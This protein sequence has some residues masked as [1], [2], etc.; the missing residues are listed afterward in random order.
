MA[1]PAPPSIEG[2]GHSFR[3][4]VPLESVTFVAAIEVW[5]DTLSGVTPRDVERY[6][7]FAADGTFGRSCIVRS[8]QTGDIVEVPLSRVAYAQ[9]V[10][11]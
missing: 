4:V 7:A 1:Q 11:R 8:I 9:P 6:E 10:R 5:S 3:N 2:R